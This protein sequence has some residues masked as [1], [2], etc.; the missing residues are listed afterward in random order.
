MAV[1]EF[2]CTACGKRFDMRVPMSLHDTLKR[3]PPPCPACTSRETRQVPST[4]HCRV[5]A[6]S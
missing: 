2:E 4:F 5:S 6:G 3:E 1:Y